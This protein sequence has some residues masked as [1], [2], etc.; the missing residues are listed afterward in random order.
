MMQAT[1]RSSVRF[2]A[3]AGSAFVAGFL[4]AQETAPS[5]DVAPEFARAGGGKVAQLVSGEVLRR[6]YPDALP[7]LL[8]VAGESTSLAVDPEP[9]FIASFDDP[10]MM[11]ATV[12]YVN[13]GDRE[14]WELTESEIEALRAYL[15]RGGFLHLDAGISAEFLRTEDNPRYG[16][17]H[18]FA[19]WQVAPKIAEVFSQVIPDATFEV[20]P[21]TDPIFRMF[22][23]GLPEPEN[24][25]E[26]IRDYVMHEKWP[27]GTYSFLGLEVD[28]RVA[29]VATPILAM[30]WGRNSLDQWTTTIGFRIR[31][32]AEGLSERLAEAVNTGTRFET[33]RED[34]RKDV[35]YT[36]EAATPAWVQEP[37]G[38][39]RIFNYY[40]TRE[41]NEYAHTFYSRLGV[42]L[43]L[44][45]FTH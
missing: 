44:Y 27:Q 19:E 22:Y 28:G 41:I 16:Q 43:L 39:W 14:D 30:G 37:D 4:P 13:V 6:F 31:E 2:L 36:Q 24:L 45:A 5:P 8:E 17:S 18:S 40:H 25:P 20:M 23:A 1:L 7:S 42:N 12:V 10:A 21:R 15:E 9:V 34:G 29:V 33:V 35:I 26:S 32:S 38:R 3:V 11:E